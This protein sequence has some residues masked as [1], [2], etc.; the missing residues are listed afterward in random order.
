MT[1]VIFCSDLQER[2][3]MMNGS[4]FF[5]KTI[6][7]ENK[8]RHVSSLTNPGSEPPTGCRWGAE[9]GGGKAPRSSCWRALQSKPAKMPQSAMSL[10]KRQRVAGCATYPDLHQISGAHTLRF[11]AARPTSPPPE[12]R[13][14]KRRPPTER[15]AER[16]GTVFPK[17][18]LLES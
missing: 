15:V 1:N 3:T 11:C 13:S 9:V 2:Y 4:S 7:S 5:L 6:S 8:N 10:R 18:E 14:K 16:F 17:D 12:K